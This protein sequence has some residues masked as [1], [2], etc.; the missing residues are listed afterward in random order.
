MRLS[1]GSIL[2][3]AGGAEAVVPVLKLLEQRKTLAGT[4]A[5]GPAQQVLSREGVPYRPLSEMTP[6]AMIDLAHPTVLLTGTSWAEQPPELEYIEAASR[7]GVPVLSVV[8]FWSNYAA[9]FLGSDGRLILPDRIAVPDDVAVAE[10]VAE[11]LPAERLMATGNPH[12]E[13]LLRHGQGFD[14]DARMAFRE[15]VGVPR[16]ATLVLFASQPIR[17]LYGSRLGYD[18]DQVVSLVRDGV[19]SVADWLGHGITLA[20]RSHPRQEGGARLPEGTPKV[21]VR[22][23][24]QGEPLSWILAADLVVGMSSALLLQAGLLGLRVVSVQ[25]GLVGIDNVPSN[26]MGLSESVVDVAGVGPALYRVL[27]R[28]AHLGSA[29]EVQRLRLHSSGAAMRLLNLVVDMG[30]RDLSEVHA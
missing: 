17:A 4:W 11:G 21:S 6:G 24:D 3:D 26:R 19:D 18:E 2:G 30:A 8:D 27:A 5:A 7:A 28:P 14:R 16:K 29:R 13:V 12:Y 20:V 22:R 25:P 23:A 1:V 10:A 9:R 15:Q